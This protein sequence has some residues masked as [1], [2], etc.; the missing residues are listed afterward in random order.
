[1]IFQ[2]HIGFICIR[3]NPAQKKDVLC[4]SCTHHC[5]IGPSGTLLAPWRPL[6]VEPSLKTV[7]DFR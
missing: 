1:M 7:R 3:A 5:Y 6:E 2:E 4:T